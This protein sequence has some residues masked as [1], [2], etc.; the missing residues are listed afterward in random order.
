MR[1]MSIHN[2]ARRSVWLSKQI[3][4]SCLE[5]CRRLVCIYIPCEEC[6]L[7]AGSIR[8]HLLSIELPDNHLSAYTLLDIPLLHASSSVIHDFSRYSRHSRKSTAFS[9]LDR[10]YLST[11][12][13]QVSCNT[14]ILLPILFNIL[15]AS[16]QSE[17]KPCA[18]TRT[19]TTAAVMPFVVSSSTATSL[20]TIPT[21]NALVLGPSRESGPTLQ[22][23]VATAHTM[24]DS[25]ISVTAA[26]RPVQPV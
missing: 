19:S 11:L 2:R 6:S 4:A 17:A 5:E 8:P 22:S 7:V 3:R 24:L 23:T 12:R 14:Y 13:F 20:A 9:S 15:T 18:S 16:L 26:E 21:I 25:E 10:Y 1:V